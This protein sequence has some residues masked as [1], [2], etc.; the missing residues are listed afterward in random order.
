MTGT[1]SF[2]RDELETIIRYDQTPG[3]AI[4]WTCDQALMRRLEA[5]GIKPVRVENTPV[6]RV[7]GKEYEVEKKWVKVSPPRQ[8]SEAQ[9]EAIRQRGRPSFTKGQN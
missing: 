5:K 4:I 8:M 9:R 6:G 7:F 3:K 1:D 2:T